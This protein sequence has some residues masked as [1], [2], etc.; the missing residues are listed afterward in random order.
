M[1]DD[2][3]EEIK[4]RVDLVNLMSEYVSL[5][6]AGTNFRG[7]CPFHKE[8][9]PSF[10][11]SPDKGLWHCFG[12]LA[13]GDLFTF[14]EKIEGIDFPEALKILALRAGVELKRFDRHLISQKTKLLDICDLSAKFYQRIL[15]DSPLAEKARKYLMEERQLNKETLKEFELGFAPDRWDTLINFLIKRKFKEREIEMAGL[16]IKSTKRENQFYDRFRNRIIFPL[17]NIYGQVNGF[18]ARIMPGIETKEGKYINT[19]ETPIFNKRKILY[20]LDKARLA[21]REKNQAILV[22]GQMDVITCHQNGVKNVICS[23][24]TALTEEQIK[25]LSRYTKNVILGFDLDVAGETATKRGVDLLLKEDFN[26]KILCLPAG[27]DPDECLR[28]D[29]KAWD[30]AAS[31][32][33]PIMDYY[34]NLAFKSKDLNKIE[35]KKTISSILLPIIAKLG[36]SVEQ[37]LWLKKLAKDISVEESFLYETFKK[38]R[39]NQREPRAVLEESKEFYDQSEKIGEFFLGLLM[40]S[41]EGKEK[42]LKEATE[43]MFSKEIQRRAVGLM[44]KCYNESLNGQAEGAEVQRRSAEGTEEQKRRSAEGL[45][46]KVI[47]EEEIKKYF[48]Y[49]GFITEIEFKDCKKE[50]KEKELKKFFIFLKK[51]YLKNQIKELESKIKEAEKKKEKEKIKFLTERANTFLKELTNLEKYTNEKNN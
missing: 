10:F 21:I 17:S 25:L 47:D 34:F 3:I 42:F 22:E 32:P 37:N 26:V 45:A 2:V 49:L 27:K 31:N 48:E 15:N 28:K 23:S 13:S 38:I 30:E 18:T 16:V 24:G 7:L 6:P 20:G 36:N 29:K 41:K 40:A 14:V 5:K 44:K 12:C 4:S 8:K 51:N 9:T 33:L 46:R 35:E 19:P 39:K 50:E 11:V 1:S 43:E